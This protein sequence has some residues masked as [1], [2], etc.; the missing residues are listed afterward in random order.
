M[1]QEFVFLP[2]EQG[3]PLPP[4][5]PLL[6]STDGLLAQRAQYNTEEAITLRDGVLLS[7][8]GYKCPLE[9]KTS[10]N[11]GPKL[12]GFSNAPHGSCMTG[13]GSLLCHLLAPRHCRFYSESH[14]DYQ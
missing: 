6:P 12:T 14:Q 11:L 7:P 1:E 9:T 3:P 5:Q 8:D 13:R 2:K 10:R 4:G